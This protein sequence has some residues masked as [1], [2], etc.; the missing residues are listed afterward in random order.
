MKEATFSVFGF[1]ILEGGK[2]I[3][4]VNMKPK[5]QVAFGARTKMEDPLSPR[6]AY[7]NTLGENDKVLKNERA[8][9][10]MGVS[11]PENG[12][13]NIDLKA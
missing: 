2:M 5:N 4:R 9:V 1:Y 12:A 7:S 6:K 13:K 3:E 11:T 8:K 10:A